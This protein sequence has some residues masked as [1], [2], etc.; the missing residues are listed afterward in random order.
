MGVSSTRPSVA[1]ESRRPHRC[2]R[3]RRGQVAPPVARIA[4]LALPGEGSSAQQNA[5]TEIITPA[6]HELVLAAPNGFERSAG[7]TYVHMAWLEL[8]EQL[9]LGKDLEANLPLGVGTKGIEGRIGQFPVRLP[10]IDIVSVGTGG[11]SIA[12]MGPDGGLRVGP[13]SAGADPGPMAYGRG[14]EA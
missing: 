11:G 2:A 6:Y 10:M 1:T 8:V 12:W 3:S 13:R 14:G 7:M 5:I 4:S 9:S